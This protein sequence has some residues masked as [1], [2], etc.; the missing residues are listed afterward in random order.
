MIDIVII[1][2]GAVSE[3]LAH[4][5]EAAEGLRLVQVRS[6]GGRPG[7]GFGEPCESGFIPLA[8]ADLYILAVS[9]R[10]V[11][12]TSTGVPGAEGVAGLVFP[13]ESV[14]AHTAGGVA[15][16]ALSEG[17]PHRAVLYPLQTFTRG[18]RIE[19]FRRRVP[20]FVE[21]TTPH[22]LD[23]V[24]RVADAL[25][26]SVSEADSAQ[27]A[28]LHLAAVFANN[29]SNAMFSLAE[30]IAR[31]AGVSY[32]LL[33]PLIAETAAKA[34]AMPSP[35][36]AQTGPAARGDGDTQAAHI[37]ILQATHPELTETYKNISEII[38]RI[39]KKN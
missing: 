35:C 3:S 6:R 1:G 27:R 7:R 9:D 28:C 34:A 37:E 5:I 24:R 13:A 39:S 11:E 2:D 22:A 18:R 33:K 19:D 23:T 31:E 20:F 26:D 36:A 10:A 17:I 8:Q 12:E 30:Q 14:V 29:F 38:W 21:G 32:D 16:G 4:E 15:V 25:S